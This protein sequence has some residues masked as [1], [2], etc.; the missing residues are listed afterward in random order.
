MMKL[1]F[2]GDLQGLHKGLN[3]LEK[4]LNFEV[5][6]D[7]IP[8]KLEK[9]DGE[10]EV[11][12]RGNRGVI[13]YHEKIHFF[14]ALGLF[15]EHL[16][17]ENE[18]SIIE[19]P[20]FQNNGTMLDLSRNA[21]MNIQTLKTMI[22]KMAIMG[23][24][25]LMLYLEDIYTIDD[26]PY[27]GYMRGRYTDEE[28][29]DCDDYADIF[30][31]EVIPCIQALAHIEQYL[32]WNCAKEIKDTRDVLLVGEEKTYKLIEKMIISISKC[33]RTNR[34]NLGMDEAHGMGRGRYLNINGY[35]E[36]FKIISCH[37]DRVLEI[38]SKYKLKPMIWSDMYFRLGSKT[39]Q[40]YDLDAVIPEYAIESIPKELQLGYW[41][42]YH[43]DEEMYIEF[44]NR[45][46]RLGSI[47]S[48]IGGIW[49]WLGMATNYGR[50]MVDSNAALNACKKEGIREVIAAMFMDDGAENNFFSGLLGL[51]L[52]AEHAYTKELDVNKLKRRVRFCT[53]IEYDAFMDLTY[54]NETPGNEK[55][56][57]RSNN[58]SKY[59]LWQDILMGLFDKHVEGLDMANHYIN[60]ESK[61][62]DYRVKYREFMIFDVPE[63]L[64]AVLKLKSVL[65]IRLK[66]AYQNGDRKT[67]QLIAE[68]EMPQLYKNVKELRDTHRKQWFKF[69]KGFGWEVLD[70]RYGGLLSRIESTMDRLKNYLENDISRIEELE[71][72]RLFFDGPTRPENVG[73][74]LFNQYYRIATANVF[75]HF[76]SDL[77]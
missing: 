61:M 68:E 58:P 42:Y 20:Q 60:L 41:D 71:A 43:H 75:T 26:E 33:F 9:S 15:I 62:K 70:I 29:K 27:F 64:C 77:N 53:G 48:F 16:Q 4:D 44:I 3:I 52:F 38:T 12:L 7:G 17:E 49:T 73:T 22:E 1:M 72:E 14:R 63:K 54:I 24:N 45:H 23:M 19:E 37:L 39:G 5:S 69:N 57:L 65:G 74:G 11:S 13:R 28:L 25:V 66:E 55:N 6:Q 21:V 50:T 59:L 8:V 10:I 30:G 51:Q 76:I 67:L 2:Q 56:N 31:I 34:I 46:K 35:E 32:N 40:Y 18:F 36:S 47:P